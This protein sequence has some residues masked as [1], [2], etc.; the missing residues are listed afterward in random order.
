VS[1]TIKEPVPPPHLALA[2]K[3]DS[4]I[5]LPPEIGYFQQVNLKIPAIRLGIFPHM[6]KIDEFLPNHM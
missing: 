4:K 6:C 1:K 2:D 3:S 5:P